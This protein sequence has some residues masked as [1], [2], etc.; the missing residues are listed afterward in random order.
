MPHDS[1]KCAR[2]CNSSDLFLITGGLQCRNC[3]AVFPSVQVEMSSERLGQ[4]IDDACDAEDE[5]DVDEL[6]RFAATQRK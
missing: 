2:R 5:I 3:R 6:E 4:M 1:S